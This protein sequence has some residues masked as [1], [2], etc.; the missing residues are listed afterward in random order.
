VKKYLGFTNPLGRF[1]REQLHPTAPIE[2]VGV[3][4]DS[5]YSSLR[6]QIPPTA[7]RAESQNAKPALSTSIELRTAGTPTI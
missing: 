3:V 5:K 1:S 4:K 7:Y 6:E 2:I